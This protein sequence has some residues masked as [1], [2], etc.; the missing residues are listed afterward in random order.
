MAKLY[1]DVGEAF[2]IENGVAAHFYAVAG[3]NDQQISAAR[4]D[5]ARGHVRFSE[6]FGLVGRKRA[7][8]GA[9]DGIFV[10]AL[11]RGEEAGDEI[12][13]VAGCGDDDGEV[14][15]GGDGLHVGIEGGDF[16]L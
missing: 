10:N 9:G 8:G 12:A 3:L 1:G 7:M 4:G 13:M 11:R 14:R 2:Q 5:L 15:Q 16:G 6:A